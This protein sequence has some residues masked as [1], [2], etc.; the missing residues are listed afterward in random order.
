MTMLIQGKLLSFEDDLTEVYNIRRTV[1]VEEQGIS[2][3]LVFDEL[4]TFAEHAIVYQGAEN[5]IAVATGRIIF[6]GSKCSIGSIAVLKEYRNKQLG[7]FIVR[8]LIN[9]AFNAGIDKVHVLTP[10]PYVSFYR[11]IG[12]QIEDK[13][14]IHENTQ[15]VNMS[16]SISDMSTQCKN[17]KNI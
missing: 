6:D 8:L 11:R 16:I 4:D 5:K 17:H 7:D 15:L 3:D 9:K 13:E 12:F 1:F 14:F 2:E 10:L